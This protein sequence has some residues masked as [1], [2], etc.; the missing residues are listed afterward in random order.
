MKVPCYILFLVAA[1][2][3]VSCKNKAEKKDHH[4]EIANWLIGDWEHKSEF[5][6]LSEQWQ[7]GN[8]STF[9]GTTFFIKG[10]DTLHN[11]S[12]TLQEQGT[13]LIYSATVKDENAD[14]PV[15]FKLTS[16]TASQLVFENPKHDFPQKI[17]YKKITADSIVAE[18]SGMQQGKPASETYPMARKKK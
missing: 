8:D 7:Q 12:I 17:T 3:A 13:D 6:N 14:L 4:I 10:K 2:S 11:E 15:A 9:V 16:E 18:V 5:G 1:F